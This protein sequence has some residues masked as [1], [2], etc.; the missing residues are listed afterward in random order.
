ML[1]YQDRL[2]P[3]AA[4]E[5]IDRGMKTLA[6]MARQPLTIAAVNKA[7][8]VAS[9][10]RFSHLNHTCG[11]MIGSEDPTAAERKAINSVWNTLPG[12][13]CF[14]DALTITARL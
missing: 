10:D 8:E 4:L 2:L 6:G 14:M 11:R 3:E 12:Y 7:R 13:T 1:T 5:N 9:K